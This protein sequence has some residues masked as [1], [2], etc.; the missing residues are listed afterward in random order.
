VII[1]YILWSFGIFSP[2]WYIVPGKNLATLVCTS[3]CRKINWALLP[4]IIYGP[5]TFLVG[6]SQ[7]D[8]I[9]PIKVGNFMKFTK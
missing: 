2:F 7:G 6:L 3:D 1:W 8:Q 9:G 4:P 5:I